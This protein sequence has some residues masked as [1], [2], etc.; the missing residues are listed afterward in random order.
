MMRIPSGSFFEGNGYFLWDSYAFIYSHIAF[1]IKI[2]MNSKKGHPIIKGTI[3]LKSNTV[4]W[5][6]LIPTREYVSQ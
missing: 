1:F 4:E 3:K 6:I 2:F 5:L